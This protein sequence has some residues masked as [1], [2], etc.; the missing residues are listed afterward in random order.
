MPAATD[1]YVYHTIIIITRALQRLLSLYWITTMQSSHVDLSCICDKNIKLISSNPFQSCFDSFPFPTFRLIN[2]THFL[3]SLKR[4]K[5]NRGHLN[6]PFFSTSFTY[7]PRFWSTFAIFRNELLWNTEP[8]SC[9][10]NFSASSQIQLYLCQLWAPCHPSSHRAV[11]K[12][13]TPKLPRQ[14]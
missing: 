7:C 5:T 13:N 6:L 2:G 10:H 14:N 11:H 8:V 4:F 1:A 9:E 12:L 3:I